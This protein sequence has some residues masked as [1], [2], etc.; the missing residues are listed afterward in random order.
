MSPE[1]CSSIL[2]L[3]MQPSAVIVSSSRDQQTLPVFHL[4]AF[5]FSPTLIGQ[6]Q[7][8]AL[9]PQTRVMLLT[10]ERH[11]GFL[12]SYSRLPAVLASNLRPE[13]V[14]VSSERAFGFATALLKW[15]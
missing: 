5:D 9:I 13:G 3:Y 15:S 2:I 11:R 6:S 10:L 4:G 7:L 1:R 8:A 14:I 12:P